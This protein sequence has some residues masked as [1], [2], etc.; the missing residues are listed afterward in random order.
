VVIRNYVGLREAI[1]VKRAQA[2]GLRVRVF[3]RYNVNKFPGFVTAQS[4]APG[5]RVKRGTTIK[6]VVS[7]W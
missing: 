5:T 4:M 1:A 3:K 2:V 6:L 7:K